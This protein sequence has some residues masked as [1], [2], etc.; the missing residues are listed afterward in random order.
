MRE[1]EAV[2]LFP[3]VFRSPISESKR[4]SVAPRR[5]RWVAMV[6][7]AISA[8]RSVSLADVT[9]DVLIASM[10]PEAWVEAAKPRTERCAPPTVMASAEDSIT[11]VCRIAAAPRADCSSSNGLASDRTPLANCA[12]TA[13]LLPPLVLFPHVTTEPSVFR[14]AKAPLFANTV[15]TPLASCPATA[16]LFAP[17]ALLPQVTTEPSVFNAAN[18]PYV[19][20]RVLTSLASCEATALLLPPFALSPH[21]TTDPFALIAANAP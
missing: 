1:R 19:E 21:V 15:W 20:W 11:R 17:W 6:C 7:R 16:L 9:L 4:L 5:A 8:R 14:A 10:L 13:L 12:A 18:A 2:R 3:A